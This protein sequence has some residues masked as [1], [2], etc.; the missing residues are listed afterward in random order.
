MRRAQPW[1]TLRART[2]RANET[3]AEQKLWDA[4][5]NRQLGG[6]KFS[7]QVSITP[8]FAD[9]VCRDLKLIVEVDGA[10]HGTPEELLKDEAR[11][12][13][14]MAKGYRVVRVLN[15]DVYNNLDGVLETL[16]ALANDD[17]D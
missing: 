10:T 4:L 2:L 15:D 9:F 3:S 5:R 17:R 11:E 8:F 7:R 16:L 13:F 1:I 6:L 14:L 12:A